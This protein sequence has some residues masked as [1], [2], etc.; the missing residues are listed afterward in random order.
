MYD[1]KGTRS[2]SRIYEIIFLKKNRKI[3]TEDEGH[4]AEKNVAT[5][6]IKIGHI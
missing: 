1:S 4:L 3:Q 5:G 6:K 2:T